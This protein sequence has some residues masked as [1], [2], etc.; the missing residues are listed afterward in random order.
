M[1]AKAI[2]LPVVVI[3]GPTASGKSALAMDIAERFNGEI[4]CA[5]SRT[6]YK[7][8]DIGT[9]KPSVKDQKRIPHWGL[10][11]VE[12]NDSYSV[13]DFK[14][15]A[16][17]KIV[18]IRKRGH[19]PVLVGGTGLYVDAVVFN[20]QF[21]SKANEKLR[22][23]LQLMSL[24]ELRDYCN[25]KGIN[26]PENQKNKRYV[27]RQIENASHHVQK[28]SVPYYK[29]II[30]GITTEKLLLRK[31]IEDR[32]EQLLQNG[33]VDE[34]II[35]GKKYDWK[36]EAMK[37]NLYPLI[38]QYLNGSLTIEDLKA[39]AAIADWRLAKRQMTWL[40][41]NPFIHWDTSEALNTYISGILAKHR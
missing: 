34:A 28:K 10:D 41:R 39:K 27:I 36:S 24:Q 16:D 37:S 31:R 6:V 4:I 22:S 17:E 9:A 13:A 32:I 29:N 3:V 11:I 15:Y 7:G 19:I 30:V 14:K 1:A 5:D 2:E 33:V 18:E 40:R 25:R 8:M 38:H 23:K 21:G 12:P 20:Y 35:L 26:L